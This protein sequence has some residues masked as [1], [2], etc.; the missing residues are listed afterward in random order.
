M[1]HKIIVVGAG[2]AGML[3]SLRL[4]NRLRRRE[5][6]LTLINVSRFFVERIRN[7]QLA[8]GTPPR[9]RPIAELLRGTGVRFV[10][11]RVNAIDPVRQI[12]AVS[13]GR[14]FSYDRLV[15]ARGSGGQ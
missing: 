15:Y 3:A 4:A 5:V 1:G 7:H 6:E 12:V 9:A 14:E 10:E 11:G 8:A 2:Y 13:D